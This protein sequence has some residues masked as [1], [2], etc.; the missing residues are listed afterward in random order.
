[1]NQCKLVGQFNL[2]TMKTASLTVLM[3][4]FVQLR[5]IVLHILYVQCLFIEECCTALPVDFP[6]LQCFTGKVYYVFCTYSP[7]FNGSH[8]N[9]TIYTVSL[10][11]CNF[12]Y[13][14][15][16][17]CTLVSCTVFSFNIQMM[18]LALNSLLQYTSLL[19]LYL[20]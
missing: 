1:M 13:R 15:N 9:F 20:E 18:D 7:F 5:L 8:V 19:F 3:N 11:N 17:S 4:Y 10:V 2:E 14:F 12:L 6:I 16:C